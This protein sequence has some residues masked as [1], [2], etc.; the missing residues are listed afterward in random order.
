M[1]E[2]ITGKR[3]LNE[4][5]EKKVTFLAIAI[6]CVLLWFFIFIPLT[7][8]DRNAQMNIVA[9]VYA[10][11]D[12]EELQESLQRQLIDDGI[13]EVNFTYV[14]A[15]SVDNVYSVMA[16]VG[17]MDSDLLIMDT[18]VFESIFGGELYMLSNEEKLLIE[19]L[20]GVSL[21][22]TEDGC[23]I[24]IHIKGDEDYNSTLSGFSEYMLFSGD[25]E[26]Y[27][28]A[29][30]PVGKQNVE[31]SMKAIALLIKENTNK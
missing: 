17:Y 4:I 14:E 25:M 24:Y 8:T 15:T 18:M 1:N 21:K 11:K 31:V 5:K 3:I 19:K 28:F 9:A 23:G 10:W 26:E 2:K 7:N 16:T 13:E 30:Y 29:I 6:A 12:N 20:A 27:D 22:Y